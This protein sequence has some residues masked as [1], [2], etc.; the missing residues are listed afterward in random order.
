MSDVVPH[1]RLLGTPGLDQFGL[2]VVGYQFPEHQRPGDWD[3]NWLMVRGE[4][5]RAGQRWHFVDPCLVTDELTQLMAWLK[6][7]PDSDGPI[8]FTE[9]LLHFEQINGDS[10]WILR[11][12]LKGEA[13]PKEWNLSRQERWNDGMSLTLRT[14]QEQLR[15]AVAGLQEDLARFPPR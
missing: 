3:S 12:I 2:R 4:V 6:Q 1:F 8:W 5:V 14:T 13:L 10:P 9:P 7:L 15:R 11:L